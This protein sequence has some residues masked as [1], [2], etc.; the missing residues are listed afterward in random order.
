M[1]LINKENQQKQT[2]QQTKG[3]ENAVL[4]FVKA[5]E[6]CAC[7]IMNTA[8]TCDDKIPRNKKKLWEKNI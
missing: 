3:S 2:N 7:W 5:Q 4:I 1:E 6:L 8:D